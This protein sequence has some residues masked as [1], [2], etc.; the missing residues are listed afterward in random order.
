MSTRLQL[1]QQLLEESGLSGEITSTLNA[2][3]EAKS[4]VRR[5]DYAYNQIQ[6]APGMLWRF[7][8]VTWEFTTVDG[9]DEYSAQTADP[10][11]LND[12]TLLDS[13]RLPVVRFY[14]TTGTVD[15]T[16]S[17]P[18]LPFDTWDRIYKIQPPEKGEPETCSI[19][20]NGHLMIGPRPDA[21]G[22]KIRGRGYRRPHALTA[23]SDAPL[24]PEEFHDLIVW[25]ALIRQSAADEDPGNYSDAA[26]QYN[27]GFT[28]LVDDQHEDETVIIEV[29]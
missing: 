27:E 22:Y 26:G 21:V 16:Q 19:S 15:D 25:R 23:D 29:A 10:P 1:C 18:A 3:G 17:L 9:V 13:R 2:T 20:P 11:I 5:I 12:W 7:L 6:R 28:A 8:W 4:I 24:L 14:P